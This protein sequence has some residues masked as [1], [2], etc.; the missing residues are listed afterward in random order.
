MNK[1][2]VM[3]ICRDCKPDIM[4]NVLDFGTVEIMY[5]DHINLLNKIWDKFEWKSVSQGIKNETTE[6]SQEFDKIG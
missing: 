2:C 5:C 4:P 1:P 6:K 3:V